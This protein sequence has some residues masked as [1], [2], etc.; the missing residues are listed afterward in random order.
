[1]IHAICHTHW[2]RE[3]FAPAS[4]TNS[5]LRELFSN[6]LKI[7]G[8]NPDYVFVLDGQTLIIEDLLSTYPEFES[9][10][11]KAIEDQKL[12]IGP[13]YAQI[14]F[15]LSHESAILFNL[16]LG[17][18][19][20][21]TYSISNKIAWTVDNFGFVSSLPMVLR[22]YGIETIF[23]W[24]GVN[25]E[26]PSLEFIWKSK[27]GSQVNAVFLL[28][29]YRNI[30]GLKLTEALAEKRVKHEYEKIKDF[31][32]SGEIPLL[33]G[34]DLD[35]NPENPAE[36]VK[37]L[38]ISSP[39]LYAQ[40]AFSRKDELKVVTGELLSGKYACVFPGTL[41]TRSYLKRQSY[42]VEKLLRYS[43]LVFSLR[44]KELDEKYWRDYIKTLIH[45]NICGVGV[46]IVHERMV[47][48]YKKLYN[49]LKSNFL[50]ELR[51]FLGTTELREGEYV[52]TFSPFQ[53]DNWYSNGKEC[54]KLESYGLGFFRISEFDKTIT[55]SK[56]S[57]SNEYYKAEFE[58]D[59]TLKVND[60]RFGILK[61]QKENGD[62][63]STNPEDTNFSVD[64]HFIG[65]ENA[66]ANHKIIRIERTLRSSKVVI[67]TK[68]RV[69]FDQTPLVRWQIETQSKGSNYLL[70]FATEMS[71]RE[72]EVF[73]K[74]PFDIVKRE[75]KVREEIKPDYYP[76]LMKVLLA[77]REIG[78][79]SKFP[80]QG[81][82]ALSDGKRTRAVMS[83]GTYEY[84]V[85]EDGRVSITLIRS[86]EWIAKSKVDGRSGDAGPLMLVPGARCEGKMNF[87]IALCDVKSKVDSPE[88]LKWFYLFDDPPM[89][90]V[91]LSKLGNSNSIDL[92]SGNLPWIYA[93][94]RRLKVYNPFSDVAGGVQSYS[95]GELELNSME[96]KNKKRV[97]DSSD[98]TVKISIKSFIDFPLYAMK[99]RI[100]QSD[101][102][103]I[104]N[105]IHRLKQEIEGEKEII[106]RS[107]ERS[108][109]YYKIKRRIFTMQRTI[110]ELEI[111]QSIILG[112]VPRKTMKVLNE[113]RAKKRIYDY[114]VELT[115]RD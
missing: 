62:T 2:D 46:D 70:T 67:R 9:K 33:D 11:R 114:I 99:R 82:V 47:R 102:K 52:F 103:I 87:E 40:R 89:Q 75:R 8:E 81:F 49:K 78:D 76:K 29:G 107:S 53:Y 59:G 1:M 32:I 22:N 65:V 83:H 24:R 37:E 26:E 98:S 38:N 91:L 112:R 14:D 5:W 104:D 6:L 41:S 105:K 10:V 74:M 61:I 80:F 34:Y 84:E 109:R 28:S 23:L 93:K 95:L 31:S 106:K 66:G 94:N 58:S 18:K 3:W 43:S 111:S 42:A 12:I 64:L 25:M 86:V 113:L 115:R 35:T 20:S 57:F 97:E 50:E 15:R 56:L 92:Y 71:D 88:F 4:V 110:K 60:T 27:D 68:E 36:V 44:G 55:D 69:I 108:S 19:D 54:Y 73:S 72:S 77:A 51:D 79:V 7:I 16:E 17:K 48:T 45:D 39:N 96:S 63:Y 30:Y 13:F 101:L 90:F 85:D 100:K 21:E